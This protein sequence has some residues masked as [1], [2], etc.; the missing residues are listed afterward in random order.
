MRRLILAA[1][2]LSA[3]SSPTSPS[4]NIAGTWAENFSIPGASLVVTLDSAGNGTGTYAIEAGRSGTLQVAGALQ[5]TRLTLTLRYDYGLTQTFTGTLTDPDHLV[6][7]FD[8]GS[9]A[10]FTRR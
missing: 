3:C 2:L 8:N 1:V 7:T 5:A 9:S 6:G 10:V 4:G